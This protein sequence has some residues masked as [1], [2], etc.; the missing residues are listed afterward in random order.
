MILYLILA[1]ASSTEGF[2]EGEFCIWLFLHQWWMIGDPMVEMEIIYK[3]K[4][5]LFLLWYDHAVMVRVD[6]P[7]IQLCAMYRGGT[8]VSA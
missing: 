3:M 2:I 7:S 6:Q 8:E 1:R 4:I 5:Y